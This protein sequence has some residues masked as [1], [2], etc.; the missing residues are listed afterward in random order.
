MHDSLRFTTCNDLQTWDESVWIEME[1][2]SA[3]SGTGPL[4]IG[5]VYRAPDEDSSNVDDFA[6]RLE[7][8]ICK[9]DLCRHRLLL[10]GDFNARSPS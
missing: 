6:R 1:A 2:G 5:C 7:S 4:I 9:I 3:P 10:V 8:A